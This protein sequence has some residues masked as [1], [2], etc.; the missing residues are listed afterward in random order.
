M[1]VP[2]LPVLTVVR[3]PVS[4]P[5]LSAAERRE[6]FERTAARYRTIKGLR[7]KYFL[8]GAGIG[9]GAY[10]WNSRADAERWFNADWFADMQSRYGVA[11][12][13]D[14]FDVPCLVDNDAERI[15]ISELS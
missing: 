5:A 2:R 4:E 15:T 1:N 11:P 3:F 9:G 10:E 7:R 8:S 13:I 12:T 6:L 14:W